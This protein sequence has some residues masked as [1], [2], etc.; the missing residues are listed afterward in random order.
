MR[1]PGASMLAFA[2][3]GTLRRP[4]RTLLTMSGVFIGVLA[5]TLIV[6]VGEG[7]A[8]FV[9]RTVST[10]ENLRQVGL[11]PGFG[12]RIREAEDVEIT[13][14]MDEARRQR[15]RRA[16]L[17]R[18]RPGT[19]IAR[20]AMTLDDAAL[21]ELRG[22]PHVV[23]V[24]P[25][26]VERYDLRAGDLTADGVPVMALEVGDRRYAERLL[27]GRAP[28]APDAREALVH[29][30]LAW[31][32]GAATDAALEGLLGRELELRGLE[33]GAEPGPGGLDPR[34]LLERLDLS[35]LTPEERAALPR[36]AEKLLGAAGAGA[37]DG[38][39]GAAPE[40]P[41]L[42]LRIV[43]VL[44][45]LEAGDDFDV[46]VD[47]NARQVDVFVPRETMRELYFAA[48]DRRRQGYRR[49][50][51]LVD[52]ARNAGTVETL[53]RDRGWSAFSVAGVIARVQDTFSAITVAVA[54]LTGIALLVAALGIVNTMVTSVLER[55]REIGLWKAV[56]ATNGQV[57]RVFLLEGATL[58][59]V[60][61]VA[62]L[63]AALLLKVPI[64]GAA[65]DL[66]AQRA[67]VPVTGDLFVV[68]AWL[69]LAGPAMATAVATLAA[70]Y[71]AHR[72][73]QVDP[74]RALRHD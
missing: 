2:W 40:P 26:L 55:T 64:E 71:P 3:E 68:P 15:L 45:D 1:P 17:A 47:G 36:I 5:L 9:E 65:L 67:P 44:R 20:R 30:H 60:G 72:A 35:V 24:T 34:A 61:G 10:H 16:A 62:G 39:A 57:R 27:V 56:G 32:W 7:L 4:G 13:G 70:L 8:G 52:D 74:V 38:G 31:R 18:S 59:A 33:E 50:V 42:R 6:S 37:R 49:A 53:L 63:L 46:I 51:V 14:P 21:A 25:I 58:G 23:A 43:G 11:S 28:A 12:Q 73:T 69:L 54:F 66:I 29:E 22:L 41:R 19:F 48:P